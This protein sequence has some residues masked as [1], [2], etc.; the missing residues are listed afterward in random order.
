MLW[1]ASLFR[2]GELGFVKEDRGGERRR[3]RRAVGSHG[4]LNVLSNS[5]SK[6]GHRRGS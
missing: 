1:D 4:G 2:R 6:L 5:R 3:S